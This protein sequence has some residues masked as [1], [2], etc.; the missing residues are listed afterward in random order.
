MPET[1]G[2]SDHDLYLYRGHDRGC[3][4][5][6]GNAFDRLSTNADSQHGGPGGSRSPIG[7]SKR[8]PAERSSGAHNRRLRT[9]TSEQILEAMN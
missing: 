7:C 1:T 6:P 9:A 3:G 5:N 4:A 2:G 8:H